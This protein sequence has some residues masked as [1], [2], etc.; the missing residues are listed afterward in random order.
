MAEVEIHTAHHGHEADAFAT[1]VGLIVAVIG[2]LLAAVTI[3]SHRAHTA[4]IVYKTEANDQW[5]YYQAKKIRAHVNDVAIEMLGA[6][7]VDAGRVTEVSKKLDA[8]SKRYDND[9]EDIQKDAHSKDTEAQLAEK[10]ALRFDLGEGFLELGLVLTSL[11]FL[12]RRKLL[13]ALGITAAIIGT[14]VGAG[15]FFVS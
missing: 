13:P 9:S 3:E 12:A 1:T 8:E 11:Y 10:Q 6:L 4:A 7:S 5:A 2:I 15:G 14:A